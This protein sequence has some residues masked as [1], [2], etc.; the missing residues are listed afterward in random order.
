VTK[1]HLILAFHNH[2][3]VGNFDDVLEDCYRKSYQPFLETLLRH[4]RLKA[5]LHYS[6]YLLMWMKDRHPGAIEM[7]RSLVRTQRVEILSG[8]FYEPILSVLPERDRVA[9]LKAY[10]GFLSKEF[11]CRPKGIWLAERV[12]EPHMPRFISGAGIRYLP[13]DDYHFTLTGLEENDLFGYYLTEDEGH[14]V[15]VFPGSEKLRYL[16]PFRPV[17]EVISYLREV[18][19]RGGI[20]LLT[21]ADDGEKFGVWPK[22]YKHC[23]ED[24]W[25]EAFFSAIEENSDWITTTTFG[26]YSADF[27]PLGRVYLPTA[28]Y[29]EMGEWALPAQAALEY[30][31]VSRQLAKTVG[32][33]WKR[34][35][36]GSIWRS[37][38]IKYPEANHLH[39]RMLMISEKVHKALRLDAAKG[40]RALQEL[41]KG[42]CN[43]A[44]WHGIFGGLYLPHL[45]SALY[46]HLLAAEQAAGKILKTLP[47]A[48]RGDFDG[49]GFDDIVGGAGGVVFAATEK[50]GSLTELSLCKAGLN[51]LDVLS[52][53]PEAYHSRMADVP[54]SASDETQTIHEQLAVREEGLSAYLI[55]DTHRRTSLLDRFLPPQTTV[56]DLMKSRCEE[57][58][59]FIDGRYE[60]ALS[61]TGGKPS[62][63]F[64]RQGR[65]GR[66]AMRIRKKLE[67]M[68]TRELRV[69]YM[70]DGVFSG[71]FAVEMNISLLGS[72]LASI[73]TGED[74]VSVR[75]IAMLKDVREFRI[76][77]PYSGVAIDCLFNQNS[78]LWY[79]P[80]ETV[81]LSEQGIER[82]FQ[83][84]CFL[85]VVNPE[86]LDRGR[87]GFRL[88]FSED[89]R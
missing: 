23:Y 77:E 85:F 47:P 82:L 55:Y 62:L 40:R 66:E 48:Q 4:P 79:Y 7:I 32:D 69:E 16:I 8:G 38:M 89:K 34:L 31:R 68:R 33:R 2:Q 3:P 71:L 50:G 80:V 88:R 43:D 56:E 37:F 70:L 83:G 24:G 11:G 74:T 10:S 41:W 73:R 78:D 35:L 18:S 84:T 49:D 22:T 67:L 19:E 57:L 63:S 53:R 15:A 86:R 61:V 42:Q 45:R 87:L 58:G 20:P 28:S 75:S 44:Y 5:V 64:E 21:M 54:D 60:M 6:G 1:L 51:L 25:L 46:R 27:A 14:H 52:R 17:E 26:E 59:D 13:I 39:K 72:P 30:E 9:Q 81:S 76:E 65:A 36:R 29:R 12:W